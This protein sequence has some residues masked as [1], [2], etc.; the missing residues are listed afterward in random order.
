M[1][2]LHKLQ[3][4]LLKDAASQAFNMEVI[5]ACES[6]VVLG[7]KVSEKMTNGFNICHGGV[8]FTLADTALAFACFALDETAVTQSVQ[9]E[10]VQSA[11][12]HDQLRAVSS[13]SHRRKRNI[14]CDIQVFNQKDQL[15]ALVRGRQVAITMKPELPLKG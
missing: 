4:L 5:S 2:I 15:I 8:I 6:Q 1:S 9:V 10:Y 13:I 11:Q 12:M 3:Q 14:F 7:L